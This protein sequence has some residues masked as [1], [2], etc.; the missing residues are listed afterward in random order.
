MFSLI[1]VEDIV[2][3]PPNK[4]GQELE[5]V[6][7]EELKAKYEG[8]I[9]KEYGFVIAVV[10]MKVNPIGKIIPGDGATY[11][12]VTFTLLSYFPEVQEVVEGEVV[13][14]EDFGAFVR[15]GPIDALLHVSQVID[16]F[17]SFDERQGALLA[18]ES[19]RVLKKD[20]IVR[21]RIT[22]VSFSRG[23]AS[24]KVG[25]TMRQP[26]LGKLEWIE[27]DLKKFRAQQTVKK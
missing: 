1:T 9:G 17:V 15:V 26:F 13:E 12:T 19:G 18:K 16:D 3:I 22:V 14:I 23:D 20:D 5:S 24:G 25:M 11:H 4:F 7:Y 6:T 10:D 27:Q 2:R 8:I 21:A